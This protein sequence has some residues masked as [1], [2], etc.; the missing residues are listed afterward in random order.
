MENEIG[1]KPVRKC[2][3]CGNW[4]QVK[5][6]YRG[7][8]ILVCPAMEMKRERIALMTSDYVRDEIERLGSMGRVSVS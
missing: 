2:P 4:H 5:Y 8:D 3:V 1:F 6:Q 7:V